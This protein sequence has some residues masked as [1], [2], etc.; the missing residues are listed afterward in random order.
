MNINNLIS[1]VSFNFSRSGGKGGQNVNKVETRVELVFNIYNSIVLTEK[2]KD[3]LRKSLKNK[4]DKEENLR[5]VS[6][7]ER[8]QLGNRK[9][10]IEKFIHIIQSSL[11]KKKK[12]VRTKIPENV[13]VQILES[14]RK[15]SEKKR[16]RK[17]KFLYEEW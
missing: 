8:S 9:K 7:S 1:E 16:D 11:I 17:N 15:Q 2:Q 6:Q 5:I 4:I 14:K 13:K 3:L 10:V 12:R